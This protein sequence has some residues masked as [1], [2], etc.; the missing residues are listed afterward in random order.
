[1]HVEGDILYACTN[2][3]LYSKD[4]SDD[5]STWQL[6]G[7]EGISLQDFVRRSDDLL[8][9]R[10]NISNHYFLLSH[11]GGK[12]YEDVTPDKFYMGEAASIMTLES[13]EKVHNVKWINNWTLLTGLLR[14]VKLLHIINVK[15]LRI[16]LIFST[17][18]EKFSYAR[19]L[20]ANPV[21]R[22]CTHL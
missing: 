8:A 17:L 20:S 2:Q 19:R 6:V 10:Y 4:L 1:M 13:T 18:V 5:E 16:S 21:E 11:D 7:F 12:T 9:M 3:G 15:Y 14:N 22:I